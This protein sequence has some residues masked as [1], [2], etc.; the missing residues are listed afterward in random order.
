[1][2]GKLEPGC[3]AV[4]IESIDG[5][6]TGKIVQCLKIVGEHSKYGTIWHVRSKDE[7]ITEYGVIGNEA[8][9]PAIWLKKIE[10]GDGI[11][12]TKIEKSKDISEKI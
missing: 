4:I 8:D 3:L 9:V 5:H 12:D 7:L 10:P 6:S 1:M 2:S 11:L